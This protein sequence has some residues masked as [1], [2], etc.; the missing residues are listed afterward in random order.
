MLDRGARLSWLRLKRTWRPVLVML[1]W[2]ILAA[3]TQAAEDAPV[4]HSRAG[5]AAAW[6]EHRVAALVEEAEPLL[7]RWGYPAVTGIVALDTLGIP[8][9]GASVMVAATVAAVRHDLNLP[10]VALLAFC[11]AVAGSQAGFALGRYGGRALLNRLPLTP[12]RVAGVERTYARWGAW[13]VLAAPFVDGLRQLSSFVAGL[14]GLPWLKFTAVNLVANVLWVAVWVG[15]T[16]LVDEH[17]AEI[18][19]FIR[20]DWP[21]LVLLGVALGAGALAW[22]LRRRT[23]AAPLS[24]QAK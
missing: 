21:W 17:A 24:Q 2:C 4:V 16:W 7:K 13:V 10:L 8:T 1:A 22:Q 18:T 12:E 6:A 23:V 14:L 20:A 9:P 19:P 15:G 11:G 3:A 5:T